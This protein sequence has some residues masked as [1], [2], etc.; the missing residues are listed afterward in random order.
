MPIQNDQEALRASG[1]SQTLS[2]ARSSRARHSAGARD[3]GGGERGTGGDDR[4]GRCPGGGEGVVAA[5]ASRGAERWGEDVRDRELV[6]R[7]ERL[8]CVPVPRIFRISSHRN[9]RTARARVSPPAATR[10]D[11]NSRKTRIAH[12]FAT[13][14]RVFDVS[15]RARAFFAALGSLHLSKK[16]SHPRVFRLSDPSRALSSPQGSSRAKTVRATSSCTSRTSTQRGSG[17]YETKSPWSSRSRRS[18]TGDT[19]PCT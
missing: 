8:R 7:R 13:P 16:T 12:P 15:A 3:G 17:A 4:R 9:R 5:I 19:K 1:F 14:A 2:V 6:Q 10:I 11:S 18:A